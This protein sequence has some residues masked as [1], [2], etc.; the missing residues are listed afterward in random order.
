MEI[1]KNIPQ[2]KIA[3][4]TLYFYLPPKQPFMATVTIRT[5]D[6]LSATFG[7]NVGDLKWYI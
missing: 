1:W 7:S 6:Q 3:L 4:Y 2:E 5:L